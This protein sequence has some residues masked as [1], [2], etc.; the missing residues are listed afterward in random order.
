LINQPIL[1]SPE[2]P[3]NGITT[4][5]TANA[6]LRVPYVEFSPTGLVWLE[7]ST[8]SRYNSLQTSVTRR[9]S[10]GLR[11]LGSYTWA[12][13]LDN[14]SGSGTGASFTQT[15]G[16]QLPLGLNRG[17]S[18][19]DRTHR[20]VL[21]F[22]Y[23]IPKWGFRWNNTAFGKRFFDGWQIAGVSVIQSGTPIS[24]LDT[25]GAALYGTSNS[26]A[27]WV[28]RANREL[29]QFSGRT[30]VRLNRYFD[31]NAFVRAGN[32]WGDTG[33][34][35]LHG[36]AQRNLDYPF[37]SVSRS[38]NEWRPSGARSFKCFEH[39]KLCQPRRKYHGGELRCDSKYDGKSARHPD[40]PQTQ[41]L[42]VPTYTTGRSHPYCQS[43]SLLAFSPHKNI[44]DITGRVLYS[45]SQLRKE[46]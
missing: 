45:A 21:N 46:C 38:P 42:V 19:F 1:A 6:A 37:T 15:E 10:K 12:K 35:I 8:D 11:L 28:P 16:D 24:I 5:T 22:S 33:R 23:N 20:A 44:L 3:V 17:P 25:S 40:G 29:A 30:Q 39:C 31:T 2:R 7:T 43:E 14:N 34:N 13:S 41:L 9:F 27:S 26:R 18:D 32:L 36:P 4:N